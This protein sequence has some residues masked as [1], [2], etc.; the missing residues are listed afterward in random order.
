[1]VC[2]NVNFKNYLVDLY[3]LLVCYKGYIWLYDDDDDLW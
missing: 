1:M 3:N 2:F